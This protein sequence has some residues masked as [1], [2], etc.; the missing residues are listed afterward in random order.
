MRFHFPDAR[1]GGTRARIVIGLSLLTGIAAVG[2][3]N[4]AGDS[5]VTPRPPPDV[6]KPTTSIHF[7]D[8]AREL[9]L[10]YT[11]P[12]QPRPMRSPDAFGAGCA[13]LDYDN[14]GWQDVL[15]VG[16]PYPSLFRN[17]EGKRFEDVTE[18][19]GL[20]LSG[21]TNWTGCAIADYDGDGH[22]DLFLTGFHKLVLFRNRG[23]SGFEETTTAAGFDPLNHEHWGSSSGFMD[24]DGDGDLDLVLLNYVIYGPEVKQYCE[25]APGV[26]SGCPPKE[27]QPEFGEIWR[28]EGNGTFTMVPAENGMKDTHGVGLVLAF[29]DFDDDGRMDFYIGN[30]GTYAELMHNLGDLRFKNLGV[31]SG[32]A[33]KELKAMAAMGADWSDFD[34]DGKLDLAVSDFQ[35]SSFALYRNN[36]QGMF[37]S[38]GDTM[39]ISGPTYKRLGFG[40][41]FFDMDNDGWPDLSFVNGHVYD[42]VPDIEPGATFR[43]PTMLFHNEQGK[44]FTDVVPQLGE[45]VGRPVLGRGSATGD[46]DNDGRIDLLVVDFEG[47]VMLLQNQTERQQHWIMFDL[48]ATGPNPFA[49]GARLIAE[50]GG[51]R[52]ISELSPASSYLSSSD[53]RVHWGLGNVTRLDKLTIRWPSGVM[54]ELRDVAADQILKI[55]QPAAK[56]E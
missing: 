14:D 39:G 29:I 3:Y 32:L 40:T 2:F 43:Q 28:N 45:D 26:K 15:L 22:L 52:W 17:H 33:M 24:L 11:W 34:R 31:E 42:N 23:E 51:Q 46:F 1:R 6:K 49:Y 30:D 16:D 41:K 56:S 35:L 36:G 10:E 27:Y 13:F 5:R 37:T 48:R 12:Q 47:P 9:S 8:V 21:D 25:L 53:R 50:A 55:V 4:L 38:V 54:Q 44:F 18:A 20:K 7:K 19:M